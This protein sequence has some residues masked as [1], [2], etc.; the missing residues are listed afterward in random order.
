MILA[1]TVSRPEIHPK[2]H[3]VLLDVEAEAL[4]EVDDFFQDGIVRRRRRQFD[5][6]PGRDDDGTDGGD[7]F[8]PV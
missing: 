8:S 5:D 7:D 2:I 6:D 4:E 3:T 1:I